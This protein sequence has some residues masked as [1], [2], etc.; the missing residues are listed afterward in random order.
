MPAPRRFLL[1]W[2]PLIGL[3]TAIIWQSSFPSPI[4][5]DLFEFQD[6]WLHFTAY[7]VMAWL[8][9]RTMDME[10]PGITGIRLFLAAAGFAILF[11]LSDEIHQSFVPGR[12][13][14]LWDWAAD[15]LGSTAGAGLFIR[16]RR[17]K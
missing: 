16:R 6:K 3:C 10:R 2:L 13:A 9:A 15:I 11:G 14:S 7:A 1:Y 8:A 12:T 4:K 5:E 17:I